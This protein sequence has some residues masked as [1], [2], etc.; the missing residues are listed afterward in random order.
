MKA[1]H[2]LNG[3]Y[4]W[5]IRKM[6]N[7]EKLYFFR[8]S[9]ACSVTYCGNF[10]PEFEKWKH[11]RMTLTCKNYHSICYP[12]HRSMTAEFFDSI[13]HMTTDAIIEYGYG[14]ILLHWPCVL[15]R[16]PYDWIQVFTIPHYNLRSYRFYKRYDPF[17]INHVLLL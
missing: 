10:K 3:F 15:C 6:S 5:S 16:S 11:S 9:I 1:V 7:D 13:Q 4:D 17:N 14:D 8:G 12:C 2:I